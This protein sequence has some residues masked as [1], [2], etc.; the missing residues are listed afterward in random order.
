MNYRIVY[1]LHCLIGIL[2][3]AMLGYSFSQPLATLS[4]IDWYNFK[5]EIYITKECI[6]LSIEGVQSQKK[7]EEHNSVFKPYMQAIMSIV[8]SLMICIFLEFI[9]MNFSKV[10]SN[11]FGLL[12]FGLSITLII[13]VALLSGFSMGEQTYKLSNTSIGVLVVSSL[14]VLFEIF[15]NKLIHRIVLTPYQLITHKK[16]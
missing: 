11:L 2:A 3:L 7:C 12:V 10:V 4:K 16:R 9:S 15:C 8:I 13:L 6:S 14:L 1:V 5:K